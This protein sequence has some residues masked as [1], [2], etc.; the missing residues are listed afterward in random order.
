MDVD[1][2]QFLMVTM[3]IISI[4]G[5]YIMLTVTTVMIMVHCQ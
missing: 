3:S 1:M 5:T 4:R 2:R